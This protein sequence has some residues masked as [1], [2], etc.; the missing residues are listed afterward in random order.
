MISYLNGTFVD[1]GKAKVSVRDLGILRGYGVFDVLPISL[2]KPFLHGKH[3]NRLEKSAWELGLHLPVSCEDHR[4]IICEL[5]EKNDTKNDSVAVRTVLT[6]GA[7]EGGSLPEN[8]ESFFVV[9][10][11]G[12]RIPLSVHEDGASVETIE[13]RRELP[14]VKSTGYMFPVRLRVR[15]QLR[16]PEA[17]EIVYM[18]KGNV[19]EASTSNIGMVKDGAVFSPH[20]GVLGGVTMM[21][22]MQLAREAGIPVHGQDISTEEFL[23]ADEVFLTASNKGI[24]PVTEIDGKPVGSGKPGE[25]TK[26]L[27]E[28]Y[29]QLVAK[30]GE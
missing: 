23:G 26:H 15:K 9:L 1:D 13:F 2:G 11:P 25:I 3:W 16:N 8:Q 22:A 17:F 12:L 4:Q 28:G 24:V 27:R 6:G 14:S 20:D 5:L 21:A 7:S 29:E 30:G 18:W 10:E 19:L